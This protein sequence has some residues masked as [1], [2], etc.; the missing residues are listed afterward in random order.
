[1]AAEE[2]FDLQLCLRV[3]M[4]VGIRVE[5]QKVSWLFGCLIGFEY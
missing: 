3:P 5:L 4:C 2:F 1:M